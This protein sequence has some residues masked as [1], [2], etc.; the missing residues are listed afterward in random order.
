VNVHVRKTKATAEGVAAAVPLEL[1]DVSLSFPRPH[2]TPLTLADHLN[3]RVPA[4][5][6]HC[7]AGRSGSGK[8]SLLRVAAGLLAPSAGSVRWLGQVL[9][10]VPGKEL[11][12]LRRSAVGYLDQGSSLLP[13]LSVLENVLLPAVPLRRTK[14]LR[15]RAEE[16]LQRLGVGDLLSRRPGL[17]SGGE[18]QRVALARA[19]LLEPAAV[20]ADEPTASL[21]R[22]SADG[23]IGLLQAVAAR[24][25]A[26][27]VT[28]HDPQLVAAADEVTTFS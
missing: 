10:E 3:V 14:A 26:V 9:S 2:P 4:G 20:L 8:T 23:V 5:A 7:F 17:L 11:P 27:L 21:D 18:R 22:G 19:L 12:A 24:G 13:G 25:T 6:I 1:V 28:S 16:L 15:E